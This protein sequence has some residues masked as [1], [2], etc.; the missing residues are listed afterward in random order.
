MATLDL[1]SIMGLKI[2]NILDLIVV[3]CACNDVTHKAERKWLAATYQGLGI[4]RK[5]S[6]NL[7]A[8]YSYWPM[9]SSKRLRYSNR[10]V[11][12]LILVIE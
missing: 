11:T 7:V 4:S 10:A 8:S 12:T 2:M 5:R 9:S 3:F 1:I 6:E